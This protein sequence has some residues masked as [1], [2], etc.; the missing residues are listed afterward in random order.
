MHKRNQPRGKSALVAMATM[1]LAVV[2]LLPAG[3]ARADLISIDFNAVGG[4]T[5]SGAA[6]I[7]SAGDQWNGINP[8]STPS[9]HALN[10]TTGA[11]SGVSLTTVSM[12]QILFS[13][14]GPFAPTPYN[15]LMQ[16]AC[17]IAQ[18]SPPASMTFTGLV[19]NQ[20]YELYFYAQDNAAVAGSTTFTI[21]GTAK[22]VN[23]DGTTNTFIE[24]TTYGHFASVLASGTGTLAI[25]ITGTGNFAGI[26]NGLQLSSPIPEPT[27]LGSIAVVA[28]LGARRRRATDDQ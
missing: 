28:A 17:L 19:P 3:A 10:T 20:A 14:P 27:A 25:S 22:T 2:A 8:S 24:G 9:P 15:T 21:N 12:G 6:V 11:A 26:V 18:P 7:G 13:P 5:Q 1:L 23:Y 4:A 16:D